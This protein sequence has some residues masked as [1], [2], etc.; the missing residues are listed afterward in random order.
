MDVDYELE[1]VSGNPAHAI[2][3]SAEAHDANEI[4]IGSRGFGRVRSA[5]GSVS[6]ELLHVARRPVTV[7][8]CNLLRD[9][10]GAQG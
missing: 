4:A 9:R 2:A 1:V 6:R 10:A 3:S 5:L 8:P 7:I